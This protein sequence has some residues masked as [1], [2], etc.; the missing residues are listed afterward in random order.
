MSLYSDKATYT[1]PP[2]VSE[3]FSLQKGEEYPIKIKVHPDSLQKERGRG[4]K[5][6]IMSMTVRQRLIFT[7]VIVLMIPSMWI[8]YTSYQT[9]KQG[10]QE[11]MVQN[12]QN[13]VTLLSQIV[14]Q[15]IEGKKKEIDFLSHHIKAGELQAPEQVKARNLLDEYKASQTALENVYI[16]TETGLFMI[17]PN[18]KMPDG[19]DPRKRDW[20]KQ[21]MQQKGQ[22][23]VSEPYLSTTGNVVVAI[24]K[25]TSDQRG[26]IALDLSLEKLAEIVNK[27]K[28]GKAGYPFI[29]DKTRKILVHPKLKA[30]AELNNPETARM[31]F[32][33][34]GAFRYMYEEEQK[35]KEMVYVTNAV[36]GWKIGGTFYEQEVEDAANPIFYKT[37]L[38]ILLNVLIGAIIVY[39]IIRSIAKPLANLVQASE[40]ISEG[41]LTQEVQIVRDDELGAL[42]R[43]FNQMSA[44]LRSLIMQVRETAEQVAASS[45]QL[46]ASAEQTGKATEHI[47]ESMQNVAAGS[48]QQARQTNDTAQTVHRMTVTV[49]QIATNAGQVSESALYTASISEEGKQ[50]IQNASQQMETIYGT[51][52]QLDGMVKNLDQHSN[53]IGNILALIKQIAEQTNLLALNAAIEAARAGEYGRGFAIVA[54]EVRKL[55]EQTVQASGQIEA[56]IVTIQQETKQVVQS[57]ERGTTEVAD[58]MHAVS[59]AGQSFE[60]ILSSVDTVTAQI[61]EVS[62]ATSQLSTNAAQFTRAIDEIAAITETTDANVQHVSAAAQEQLA[63]MEEIISS[64]TALARMA[65]QL[66]EIV[67]KFKV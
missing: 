39:F 1:F 38:I 65:E 33:P 31:F 59:I 27:T 37:M 47:T 55:A 6:K 2:L 18:M 63:S 7:F 25:A 53:L 20:Y 29:A 22:V 60:K 11:Q 66:Q 64:S 26:V 28:I 41:D 40:K 35:E 48:E 57:M 51:V 34:S 58:G 46:S 5:K 10:V 61:Q 36:T 19:F 50:A 13:N 8:G 42:A 56:E 24:A 62:A 12:A 49:Q 67:G 15:V 23:I 4:M 14:D 32:S 54:E 16:G 3:F 9:A 17:S 21:A 45:E 52:Q 43:S 30:G 44:S